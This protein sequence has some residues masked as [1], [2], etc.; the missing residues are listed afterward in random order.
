MLENPPDIT[1][2]DYR[3]LLRRC[4]D[5]GWHVH[6]IERPERMPGM[7]AAIEAAGATPVIDHFGLPKAEN[8]LDDPAFRATL[9]ALDRGRAWAKLSAG[10]RLTPPS[11]AKDYA[12][13][14]TRATGGERLVFATD[15]PFANHEDRMTYAQAVSD[16]AEWVPDPAM[17]RRIGGRNPLQL[18]FA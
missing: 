10:Y 5:L 8:G 12:E 9:E 14:L 11:A 2:P 13:A 17:R 16:F 7:I 3:M 15:W 4:A 1:S 6:F 18:Y